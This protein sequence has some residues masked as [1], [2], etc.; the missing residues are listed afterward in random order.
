[1]QSLLKTTGLLLLSSEQVGT[2]GL[3][4]ELVGST[5]GS[6]GPSVPVY[7][8]SR[9]KSMMMI[10]GEIG[11]FPEYPIVPSLLM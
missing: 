11:E 1:M 5:V 7:V 4:I 6:L 2:G 9:S 10:E 8:T 3:M